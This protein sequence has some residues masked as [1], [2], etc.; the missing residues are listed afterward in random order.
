MRVHFQ[1]HLAVSPVSQLF[2]NSFSCAPAWG[3]KVFLKSQHTWYTYCFQWLALGYGRATTALRADY[4][5]RG[6]RGVPGPRETAGEV[7]ASPRG[8]KDIGARSSRTSSPLTCSSLPRSRAGHDPSGA[9]T[10]GSDWTGLRR[11]SGR[12]PGQPVTQV[13]A[14][15]DCN[16]KGAPSPPRSNGQAFDEARN[17]VTVAGRRRYK[18]SVPAHPCWDQAVPSCSPLTG[19][20]PG[21]VAASRPSGAAASSYLT[22]GGR[23]LA[24]S[25]DW[26]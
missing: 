10:A 18:A 21:P 23:V 5:R 14:D 13:P 19:W 22:E 9:A 3:G 2:I 26:P 17:P 7:A 16:R 15:L 8:E 25:A 20:A 1:P 24:G 6:P 12:S 4:R 11:R